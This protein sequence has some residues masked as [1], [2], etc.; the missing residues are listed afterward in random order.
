MLRLLRH[1]SWLTL[2]QG[3]TRRAG[4]FGRL[5]DDRSLQ[6][7]MIGNARRRTPVRVS[8]NIYFKGAPK[9]QLI[10]QDIAYVL[11]F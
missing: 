9:Y 11:Q 6:L 2:K 8:D 3:C 4:L 10:S 7:I 1:T 5:Y